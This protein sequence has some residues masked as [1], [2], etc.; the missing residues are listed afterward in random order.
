MTVIT[1]SSEIKVSTRVRQITSLLD[2]PAA[3]RTDLKW[4]VNLP[5]GEQPWQIGLITGPSGCGKSTIADELWPGQ[6]VRQLDWPPD[7]SILDSF[8]KGVGAQEIVGLL[9]SVGLGSAP[10]WLRPHHVLSTGEQFRAT[11]ARALAQADDTAPL[12]VDEFTSVVDRQVAKI[13]SHAIQKTVRKRGQR[14]VAVSCHADIV[15]WLQPDWVYQPHLSEFTWRCLQRRPRLQLEIAPVS[16]AVWKIFRRHHYL[17]ARLPFGPGPQAYGGFV[18]GQCVAFAWVCG[19]PHPAASV[20]NMRRVRRLVVLPD[21]QGLGIGTR[22]EEYL[23][24]WYVEHGYR[25]R[26]V[27]SH[28]GMVRYYLRSPRWRLERRPAENVK[29]LRSG[30]TAQRHLSK[31][32]AD[33]RN[34]LTY[35]FVYVPPDGTRRAD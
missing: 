35:A 32:Q 17:N 27:V 10:A 9:T 33:A 5:L 3:R 1:R 13:C 11:M 30:R 29:L 2:V 24:Q 15:D 7:R 34:L 20:Q 16:R 14:L 18:N 23:A 12:V 6:V 26:S 25:F 19:L 8:P 4:D 21:W 22:M 31:H 28:P